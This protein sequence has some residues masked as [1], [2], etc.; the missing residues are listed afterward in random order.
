[1]LAF[2]LIYLLLVFADACPPGPRGIQGLTGPPGPDGPQGPAGPR[3]IQGLTGP[4]G[5]IGLRGFNGTSGG[6][7]PRGPAGQNATCSS[8][9]QSFVPAGDLAVDLG[10]DTHRFATGHV[11]SILAANVYSSLVQT[12][13][14]NVQGGLMQL[15]GNFQLDHG[16]IVNFGQADG[17]LQLNHLYVGMDELGN[18]ITPGSINVTGIVTTEDTVTK[19]L[20]ITANATAGYVLASSDDQGNAHW[21]KPNPLVV[22]SEVVDLNGHAACV[23][24]MRVTLAKQGH[25][26]MVSIAPGSATIQSTGVP[27]YVVAVHLNSYHF[28]PS[29]LVG[30]NTFYWPMNFVDDGVALTGTIQFIY[31]GS[32]TFPS[33]DVPGPGSGSSVSENYAQF[34]FCKGVGCPST[35][36]G[37]AGHTFEW[38]GLNA[39]YL[40]E[41][42]A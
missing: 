37:V 13:N 34:Q 14:I 1:M 6:I 2:V 39:M 16:T 19:R 4:P 40:A 25:Y 3:G 18:F 32:P 22:Y 26:V 29:T 21:K 36:T 27:P 8:C 20:Q 33:Y 23:A 28:V 35:W 11:G 30:E 31:E 5:P 17:S 24:C 7:G 12:G 15:N 42:A 38:G 9:A 10:S 41:T